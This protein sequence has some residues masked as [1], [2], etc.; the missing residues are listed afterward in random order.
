MC[1]GS[2]LA[3]GG[4]YDFKCQEPL[5]EQNSELLVHRFCP[6]KK[7]NNKTAHR[8]ERHISGIL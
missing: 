2:L 8:A 4:L 3:F 1:G 7:V 5:L 6:L